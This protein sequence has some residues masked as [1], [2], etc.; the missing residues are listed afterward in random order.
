MSKRFRFLLVI[1]I[2]I[3]ATVFLIPSFR[4][5]LTIS[6][7]EKDIAAGSREEIKE[8][9][10]D[11]AEAD[12]TIVDEAL[13]SEASE[14][15]LP[16][17]LLFL[18]DEIKDIMEAQ[19]EKVPKQWTVG[20]LVEYLPDPVYVESLLQ[21]RYIEQ[22]DDIKA[23]QDRIIT[24][25]LDL[26]GGMKV[27]I[28]ADFESLEEELERPLTEED[29]EVAI[30]GAL[31]I[32]NNRIDQ[33]GVKEPQ[34]RRLAG[35][36]RIVIDMPGA[37]DP[38]RIRKVIRGKGRLKFHLV[39]RE[40]LAVFQQYAQTH[41][42]PY[43]AADGTTPLDP[44]IQEVLLPGT[45]LRGVYE[46]D[47]FGLDQQ[48]GYTVLV[49]EPG[50]GGERI[51]NAYVRTDPLTNRPE[52]IFDLD[53]AGAE[54]FYDLTSENQGEYLAV[55]LDDRVKAQATISEAIRTPVRVTGF[56]LEEATDLAL[57]LKTGALPVPLEII[58]QDSV[59]ASLGEDTIRVGLR[60][61]FLGL[62]MV[63][64]F[65]LIYYKG[66]GLIADLA[67]VLNF[68]MMASLLSAFNF[69]LTLPGIAGFILTVG[70][71][72]D[73][74]VIIF[75]RIK[76]EYRLGKSREAA[77]RA[78]FSKAFWTVMDANIT[79]FIAA[80]SLA[81]FGKGLIAGFAVMLAVGIVTSMVS[82]LFIS[83][84]IFDFNTDV[85]GASRIS[86]SWRPAK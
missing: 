14:A 80:L 66:A 68:Y 17:E 78:G 54:S 55:V 13:A 45:V 3:V 34:I 19:G 77:I 46:K 4:W 85:L 30:Q 60:A 63:I 61:I 42:E 57:V 70:M 16:A 58:S 44:A 71:A 25:G 79:T 1:A 9:A 35:D 22:V 32:L 59:G 23:I 84:L 51:K 11:R 24:L 72:V 74:N 82:A 69:T 43:L 36:R 2:L 62:A 21:D 76:E 65:M 31:E 28:E 29:R 67:L 7:Q 64:A 15:P 6:R 75:E 47:P 10:V 37:A 83:R 5:Y 41:P 33:F 26:A 53:A 48:V 81:Y 56:E 52:V 49:E 27:T 8:Y 40:S 20:H 12:L 18:T 86:I 73:A 39:D 50:M 38:E